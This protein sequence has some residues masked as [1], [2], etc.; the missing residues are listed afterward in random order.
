MSQQL[1]YQLRLD[2]AEYFNNPVMIKVNEIKNVG[3]Y[4]CVVDSMLVASQKK[5]LVALVKN[6][7]FPIFER[8]RL[9]DI[10][11]ISFQSR[12]LG[13]NEDDSDLKNLPICE[14][15]TSKT[16]SIFLKESITKVSQNE[17]QIQYVCDTVPIN[18]IL[19][20]QDN[21]NPTYQDKSTIERA[22]M[23]FNTVI[24]CHN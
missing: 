3:V 22:I 12:Q 8:R 19:L 24:S 11:W 1:M 4:K 23:Y 14:L 6:D 15:P 5:Y 20:T 7:N 13:K 21:K 18:I 10:N 2:I 16:K 17:T 9:N